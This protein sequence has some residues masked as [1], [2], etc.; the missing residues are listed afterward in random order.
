MCIH[1]LLVEVVFSSGEAVHFTNITFILMVRED[2]ITHKTTQSFFL[3]LVQ[4]TS[5]LKLV[6]SSNSLLDSNN[7][8]E[9]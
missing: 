9:T 4:W 5:C 7:E 2:L 1:F 8:G 6:E 3:K